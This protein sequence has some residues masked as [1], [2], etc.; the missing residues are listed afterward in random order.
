MASPKPR[1]PHHLHVLAYGVAL[2][3]RSDDAGLLAEAAG[4]LPFGA[5]V[6]VE[7][8]GVTSAHVFT[9]LG[10]RAAA[11]FRLRTNNRT[12]VRAEE[13]P[14]F[15]GHLHARLMTVIAGHAPELLFVHAGVVA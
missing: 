2:H 15:L 10:A 6:V 9:L 3:L 5:T 7:P 4:H 1:H 14:V 8:R 12:V 11:P 13:L